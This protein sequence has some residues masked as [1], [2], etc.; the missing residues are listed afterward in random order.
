MTSLRQMQVK[1]T[2][3]DFGTKKKN[4]AIVEGAP[5]DKKSFVDNVTSIYAC[6]SPVL[7]R[8]FRMLQ[9]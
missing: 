4:G 9:R 1:R 5:Q 7:S 8:R 2:C 6:V 3:R